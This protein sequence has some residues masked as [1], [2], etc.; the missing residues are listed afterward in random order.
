M[1]GAGMS[2]SLDGASRAR[3]A[4][5]LSDALGQSVTITAVEPLRGGAIQENWALGV[6]VGGVPRDLV[7]RKD[8]PASI[9]QSRSR[10]EEF[11]CLA[12]AHQAGVTVPEPLALCDDASVLGSPFAVM[13]RVDGIG[14]GPKLVKDAT[15]GGDREALAHRLGLEMARIHVIVPD[16]ALSAILG[17][18]PVDPAAA[19][20]ASC[21]ASLDAIGVVRPALEWALRQAELRAPARRPVSFCH[22]DFRTGNYMVDGQGLT[23]MLDWE[24]A[25]WS[26][27]MEDVGWF[28]ARCWRFSRPDLEA[29]GIGS[30][31]AF[32]AGYLAGG[33]TIDR[34]AVSFWELMAHLRWAVTALEQGDR[35]LSG[36][37]PSLEHAMTG[38][39]AAE[40]EDAALRMLDLAPRIEVYPFPRPVA[41]F[42]ELA[43][44]ALRDL[45]LASDTSAQG[46]ARRSYLTALAANAVR[47]AARDADAMI[48]LA[49]ARGAIETAAGCAGRELV[50]AIRS[51]R[52]D[53]APHLAGA[54]AHEARLRAG[55]WRG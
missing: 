37:E 18:K 46:E 38:R 41:D 35:H 29:G 54:L 16:A 6:T 12:A 2:E 48:A 7:L 43:G 44:E 25:G 28:T 34:T 42:G 40:L 9:G 36:R 55:I 3:L 27:P 26:D 52:L 53:R 1:S 19:V 20:I 22:R 30:R 14:L 33:G 50:A 15:L 51:G 5:W 10:R 21:R 8:A 45:A 23:A 49:E 13:A 11:V 4:G 31:A 39:I 17:P 24:F 32:E 47:V